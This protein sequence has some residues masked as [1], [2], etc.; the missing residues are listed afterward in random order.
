MLGTLEELRKAISN[1][2]EEESVELASEALDEIEAESRQEI[3]AETAAQKIIT[4][5]N[6]DTESQRAAGE[7]IEAITEAEAARNEFGQVTLALAK[8]EFD[9]QAILD[10]IDNV[11]QTNKN[12]QSAI[13]NFRRN[14]EITSL[15][16]ILVAFAPSETLQLPKGSS[17]SSNIYLE[18]AGGNA[19]T[20]VS[21]SN[22][23]N[24]DVSLNPTSLD[25]LLGG[26]STNIE[27]EIP[28]DVSSGKYDVQVLIKTDG[29]SRE[30]VAISVIVLSKNEYV[31]DAI[32]QL[33][34]LKSRIVDVVDDTKRPSRQYRNKISKLER[35]L[36]TLSTQLENG[37]IDAQRANKELQ[38]IQRQLNG[39]LGLIKSIGQIPDSLRAELRAQTEGVD[40]TL[41]NGKVAELAE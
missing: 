3:G 32:G 34:S 4:T 26:T 22:I 6:S 29:S 41:E 33:D 20:N 23:S 18:N 30:S 36:N 11:I 39:L 13:D 12:V 40:Q 10:T 16:P 21:I 15:D 17:E 38:S 14:E 35:D 1:R 24:I 2:N 31:E 19:A 37:T 25:R 9:Q 28:G 5:P 27:L 8:G 7:V